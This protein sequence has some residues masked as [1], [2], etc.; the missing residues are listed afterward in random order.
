MKSKATVEHRQR[1]NPK[2]REAFEEVRRAQNLKRPKQQFNPET[3][4]WNR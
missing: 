1:K 2:S 3:K 4:E